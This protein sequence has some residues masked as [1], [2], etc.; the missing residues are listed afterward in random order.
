MTGQTAKVQVDQ[1]GPTPCRWEYDVVVTTDDGVKHKVNF[2]VDS[3][4]LETDNIYVYESSDGVDRNVDV[5]EEIYDAIVELEFDDR[6]RL[7]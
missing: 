3:D 4:G 6:G 5:P 2:L 1:A 7:I